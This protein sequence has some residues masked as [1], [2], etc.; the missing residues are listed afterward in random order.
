MKVLIAVASRHGSTNEIGRAIAEELRA[1]GIAI[2]Q[3]DFAAVHG[4]TG[5]DAAV[6]GSAVYMDNWL[7]D[8]RHFVDRHAARLAAMPVWL[9]SSG[10]IGE[11]DPQ[12][13]GDPASVS[14]LVEAIHPRGHRVF[15][16]KLDPRELGFVERLA[17][18]AVHAPAGD[19]RDWDAVR[20]WAQE[21][22]AALG[23]PVTAGRR[24]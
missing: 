11:D 6:L 17:A 8:A 9:F 2:E 24:S 16:G 5:F 14:A 22:A 12:P 19:F 3:Q 18:K 15:A 1:A 10:P 4:L 21:I 7:D 23:H 20:T 13:H